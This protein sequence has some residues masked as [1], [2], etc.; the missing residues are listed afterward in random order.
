MTPKSIFTILSGSLACVLR[1][2]KKLSPRVHVPAE[3]KQGDDLLSHFSSHTINKY[4]VQICG[5][6]LC[7]LLVISLFKITPKSSAEVLFSIS[8][9]KKVV[10]C[11]KEKICAFDRLPIVLSYYSVAVSS[12]N[13]S[14]IYIK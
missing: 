14:I 6:V 9:C 11:L 3:V 2:K 5:C 8:K 10:M 13:E 12:I 7:F 1:V 4:L